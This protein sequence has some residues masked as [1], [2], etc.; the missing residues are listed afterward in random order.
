[1]IALSNTS[2]NRNPLWYAATVNNVLLTIAHAAI[3]DSR[4]KHYRTQATPGSKSN[5]A[6]AIAILVYLDCVTLFLRFAL[7]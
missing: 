1:M 5:P 7:E 2:V 3:F 6:F 4:T